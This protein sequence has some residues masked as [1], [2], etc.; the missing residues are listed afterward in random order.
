MKLKKGIIGRDDG[1]IV[2]SLFLI[3]YFLERVSIFYWIRKIAKIRA[4]KKKLGK[5]FVCSYIFP[6]IWVI[7]NIILQL[8]RKRWR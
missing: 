2:Q 6:E 8:V 5:P 3:F 1:F 7:A 4:E